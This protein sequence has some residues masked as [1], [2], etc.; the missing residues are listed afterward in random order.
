MKESEFSSLLVQLSDAIS[1]KSEIYVDM[2]RVLYKELADNTSNLEKA[3]S[4]F[5]LFKL[6]IAPGILKPTDI[7]VLFETIELT[8]LK[9]LKDI[10]KKYETYPDEVEI[11]KFSPHR[12]QI[13]ALGNVFSVKDLQDVCKL[14]ECNFTNPWKLI[15]HLEDESVLTENNMPIFHRRLQERK[16]SEDFVQLLVNVSNAIS[17]T[18]ETYVDMLRVLYTDFAK[19]KSE[20]EKAESAF[21]LFNVLRV[22]DL[23]KPKDISV[24]FETVEVTGWKFL[25]EIIKTYEMYPAEVKITNF[26]EH[27]QHVF[28]LG[29]NFTASDCLSVSYRFKVPAKCRSNPWKLLTFL[30]NEKI[31]S[32]QNWSSFVQKLEKIGI[33]KRSPIKRQMLSEDS[34]IVEPSPSKKQRL[35]QGN[36]KASTS[37]MQMTYQGSEEASTIE[38]QIIHQDSTEASSLKKPKLDQDLI[39]RKFVITWLKQWYRDVNLMTPSI[40]NEQYKLDIAEVFT[41]LILLQ[42]ERQSEGAQTKS[43]TVNKES[44][45]ISLTELLGIIE[46]RDPCKVLITGKGGMGKTTLL[47]YIAHKWATDDEPTCNVFADKLLFLINIRSIGGSAHFLDLI[48]KQICTKEFILTKKFPSDSVETFLVRN[49]G[50]IV[51]LLDGY[52]ELEKDSK[53]PIILFKGLELEKST[54]VLTSRPENTA[55]LVKCC[56]VHIKVNGFSPENIKKYLQNHFQS[57]NKSELG[58]SLITEFRLDEDKYPSLWGEGHQEAFQLCSSPLLLLKICTIWEQNQHLPKDMSD[59]FKELFCCILSQYI[60]KT[61]N[62]TA[63]SEFD[64]IPKQYK[65]AIYILGKCM[66]EGLKEN[67]LSIDKYVLTKMGVK[68][69]LDIDLALKLGFVYKDQP[70]SRGDLRIFYTTPSK[71]L[72]EALAGYYLSEL[73]WNLE[74]DEYEE[75]R[76]NEYLHM[77]RM[78]TIGFLGAKAGKMLKHWLRIRASNYYSIAQCFRYIKEENEKPVLQE[79]DNNMSPEMKEY[80]EQMCQSFR[81]V[82][83]VDKSD[84]SMHLFKAIERCSIEYRDCPEKLEEKVISLAP[85]SSDVSSNVMFYKSVAHVSIVVQELQAKKMLRSD[86]VNNQNLLRYISNLRE[87]DINILSDEMEYLQL[88][89]SLT[90]ATLNFAFNSTFLNHFLKHANLSSLHVQNCPKSKILSDVISDLHKTDVKLTLTKLDISHTDLHDIDGTLLGKLFKVAPKLNCLNISSCRLSGDILRAMITECQNSEVTLDRCSLDISNN[91]IDDALLEDILKAYP[92]LSCLNIGS[93]QL[94]KDSFHNLASKFENNKSGIALCE[95][96]FC[97]NNLGNLDGNIF[98]RVLSILPKLSLLNISKCSLSGSIVNEI[99]DTCSRINLI[100]KDNMLRLEGNNLS[101]IN[102]KLLVELIRVICHPSDTLKWSDYSFT[103]DNIE[104]LVNSVGENGILNFQWLDLSRIN[105]SSISGRTLACLIK[106]SRNLVFLDMS[107]CSLKGRIVNEMIEEC[108]LKKVVLKKNVLRLEGNDLSSIDGKSLAELVNIM[109]Y[110]SD[111]FRWSD[112]FLTADNLKKLIESI[113]ENETLK[114]KKVDLSRI[115]LSVVTGKLLACLFK[116]SPDLVFVNMSHCSLSGINVNEMVDAC[117]GMNLVLKDNMLRLEGNNISLTNGKSLAE[118]VRIMYHPND[119]LKWSDYSLQANNLES[120]VKSL[121]GT[122]NFKKIDFREIDLSSISG[123]TIAC[124]IKV[125]TDLTRIDMRNCNVSWKIVNE[126]MKECLKMKVVLKE[127]LLFLEGNDLSDID[128]KSLSELNRLLFHDYD[129]LRWKDYSLT[130]VNLKKLIESLS[131]G[132]CEAFHCKKIDF[133]RINL[134]STSGKTLACIFK[135][136]ADLIHIDM[137]H[138]S[139]SGNIINEM[140][141]EC[142]R[143]NVVLKDKLL[144]LDGN[145]LS[146]INGKSLT[147]LANVLYLHYDTFRWSEY[148]LTTVNLKKLV[149]SIGENERL[150]F[151][152]IDLSGIKLSSVTGR[153]L[154]CLFKISPDLRHVDMSHCN[155]TGS[156]VNEVMKECSRIDLVLKDNM[157]RLEGN[158]LS[159]IDGKSLTEL[160]RVNDNQNDTFRLSDY[161]L[162]ATSLER[163]VKSVDG[164]EKLN[165]VWIEMSNINLFSISGTALACLF[166]ISP[167]LICVDMNHCNLSGSIVNEMFNECGREKV[168]LKNNMLRMVGN[169]LS[170]ING[171]SLAELVSV[172]HQPDGNFTWSS[173]SLKAHNLQNLVKSVGKDG[174]LNLKRVDLSGIDL[175]LIKGKQLAC[176]LKICVKLTFINMSNCSLSG[177]IFNEMIE[178][179]GWMNVVLKDNMLNLEGND[180]SDIDG[181]SLAELIKAWQYNHFLWSDCSLTADNLVQ[182]VE[183][184]GKNE[185][186][187]WEVIYLNKINLSSISGKTLACLLKISPDLTHIDISHCCIS[188]SI[189]N[190]MIEECD[191]LN[192]VLKTNMLGLKGNDLSDTDGKSLAKFIRVINMHYSGT[193]TWSDYS[194][195]VANLKMLVESVDKNE[196]LNLKSIDLSMINLSSISGRTLACLFNI[197]PDLIHIYMSNCSLSGNI[198]NEMVEQ[199]VRMNVVLKDNMLTLVGNDL[200]DIDG[201]SLAEL[202]SAIHQP[203]GN[204]TWSYYSF[205][206]DNLQNLVES[207]IGVNRVL[208][209]TRIDISRIDLSGISGATLACLV[210]VSTDLIH[211]DMSNCSLS[212]SNVNEM[213]EEC[214]RMNVVLKNN[215]L[216][217][218]GNDLSDI[219]GKA[220]S[221]LAQILYHHHDTVRWSAYHFTADNIQKLVESVG[222]NYTVNW[223]KIELSMINLSSISGNILARFFKICS[224]LIHIYMSNCSLSGNILNEM[225]EQCSRRNVVLKDKMLNVE[226]ND[227]SDINSRSLKELIRIAYEPNDTFTWSYY[228]L[229]T[230]NLENLVES[231]GEN[232]TFNWKRINLSGIDMSS[233]SE[234]T[235]AYL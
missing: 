104:K 160:V 26:S 76:S 130:A 200:S 1:K 161:Y 158:D 79:L 215:M 106:I 145:N 94:S 172:I 62:K 211:I 202:V 225:V 228:S 14:H 49:A 72:S 97:Q 167:H 99:M 223:K 50:E 75:I 209:W 131:E 135:I 61:D 183:S 41:E 28:A 123:K 179:C 190:E 151:E 84:L 64:R 71:L 232:M 143:M 185:K 69:K 112:Y 114:W 171:K 126:M 3:K 234:T 53:D 227:F 21:D 82:L 77:T 157:L 124:L 58:E 170:D 51:I 176:F 68:E 93:C 19:N 222:E 187:N 218:E 43:T 38:K 90:S 57:I 178:E 224:D 7:S 89:Y 39:I 217:L 98:A 175:S 81:S 25:K 109:Y 2:L 108:C 9:Y 229:T 12:Q 95:L 65:H 201:K 136:F 111:S 134:S 125:S 191:R 59:L 141:E 63:I 47:R 100:L 122:C 33:K 219:N 230:D 60:C 168:V 163:L 78:F 208:N 80:N 96:D 173:Y 146:D 10:I 23:L 133:S 156:I 67:R 174:I 148:S 83:D 45:L 17:G 30:E 193:F 22:G 205:T 24:L 54:V 5:E 118:I 44:R 92:N 182:L 16:E 102:G 36:E 37:E 29:N 204:F 199:C 128:G 32:V 35:D 137:R 152:R 119:T 203:D 154:A 55:D 153:T 186:L 144:S 85:T 221:K 31:I 166:K 196:K 91:G 164:N 13:V 198:L 194:L 15:Q 105:L 184:V 195:T 206:S 18:D 42:P 162:T 101:D 233:V 86:F 235:L 207:T 231:V 213:I 48:M 4:A 181:K 88:K 212:G 34:D 120:L 132:Q 147:K 197:S 150:N 27:R 103:A 192:V 20:L 142:G 140:M 113:N 139:L 138:C 165:W 73:K 121:G 46:T 66:Y 226:G 11:S 177:S 188:V 189:V 8:G 159:N 115:N 87:K 116:I 117:V 107:Y 216:N 149:E 129:T 74:D 110:L 180:L 52:D 127:N 214:G 6:L 210:T 56:D 70:A 40:W 169:D 220:L 155:L